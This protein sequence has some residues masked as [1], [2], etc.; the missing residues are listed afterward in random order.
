MPYTLALALWQ[1]ATLLLYLVSI[2]MILAVIRPLSPLRVHPS[3]AR[4]T[5][6]VFIPQ[7]WEGGSATPT[8]RGIRED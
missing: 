2:R 6:E 7:G 3:L 5:A 4:F 1:A 8:G